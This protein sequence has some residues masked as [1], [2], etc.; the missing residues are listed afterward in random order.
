MRQ[1]PWVS[2]LIPGKLTRVDT[3]EFTLCFCNKEFNMG[4]VTGE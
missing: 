4:S 2:P 3:D 1:K